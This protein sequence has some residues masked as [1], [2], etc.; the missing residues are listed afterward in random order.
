MNRLCLNFGKVA[1]TYTIDNV[2]FGERWP[3]R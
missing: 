1:A 3:T 2:E